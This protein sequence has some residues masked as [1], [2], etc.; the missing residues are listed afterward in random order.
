MDRLEIAI[1]AQAK[2]AAQEIDI[3]Y[4][5][6]VKVDTVLKSSA[7]GYTSMA[8]GINKISTSIGK[9]SSA[10]G[11]I[12]SMLGSIQALGNTLSSAFG[13]GASIDKSVTSLVNAIAK[14]GKESGGILDAANNMPALTASLEQFFDAMAQV[15]EIDNRTVRMTQAIARMAAAGDKAG[16]VS[17]NMSHSFSTTAKSTINLGNAFKTCTK[18]ITSFISLGVKA[19]VGIVKLGASA[20]KAFMNIGNGAKH[21]QRATIS[22]KNLL[23]VALG[24]YGIRSLFNWGKDAIELS[25]DLTEVQNVVEN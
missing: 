17:V 10:S 7:R 24:F 13:N 15:P 18:V 25:S 14:L 21:V 6:L 12:N 23:S 2:K 5:Q 11:S 8:K 19:Q 20:V 4:N 1:E 9:L 16:T 3:L 22:L